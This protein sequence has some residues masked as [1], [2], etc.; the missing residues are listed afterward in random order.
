MG[1]QFQHLPHNTRDRLQ[2]CLNTLARSLEQ[3]P[4]PAQGQGT[5]SDRPDAAPAATG[6]TDISA[7][8]ESLTAE[9]RELEEAMKSSNVEGRVLNE[10]RDSVDQIRTTAWA[11]QQ[12]VEL[13]AKKGDAYSVLTLLVKERVRRATQLGK[14]LALDIEASELTFE[15][16]GIKDLFAVID[17]L[18]RRLA[19]FFK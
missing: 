18:Y 4:P 13:E 6:G 17:D 11:A 19:R 9:L 5:L 16:E 3:T 14:D 12:W 8:L 1:V 2:R 7:R 15:T 10:F